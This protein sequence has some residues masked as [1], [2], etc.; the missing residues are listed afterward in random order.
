MRVQWMDILRLFT[1][2]Q[3]SNGQDYDQDVKDNNNDGGL[4]TIIRSLSTTKVI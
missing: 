1:A 3:Y 2:L 4:A